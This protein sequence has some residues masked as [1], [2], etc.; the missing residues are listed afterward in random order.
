MTDVRVGR[1]ILKHDTREMPTEELADIVSRT[2]ALLPANF[3]AVAVAGS[4]FVVGRDNAGWT[5]EDYVV[6]RA[7]SGLVWIETLV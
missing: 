2:R 6:P 3:E 4:L 5:M 7:A 1:V